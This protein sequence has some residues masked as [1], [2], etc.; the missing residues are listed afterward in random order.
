[1]LEVALS[2]SPHRYSLPKV[3]GAHITVDVVV[4]VDDF[5]ALIPFFLL[6]RS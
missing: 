5:L 4:L 6:N 2:Q 3:G 1:M